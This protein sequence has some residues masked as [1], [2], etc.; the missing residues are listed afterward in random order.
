LLGRVHF[1]KD[2]IGD[3][4][5]ES[6]DEYVVFRKLVLDPTPEQPGQPGALFKVRFRFAKL[7]AAANKRLSLIPAPFIAAQP[8]FRSKTWMLGRKTGMFQGVYEWDS[9]AQAE[10][11]TDSLPL[12]LMKKRAAPGSISFEVVA[13]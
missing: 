3:V 4:H 9:L 8:G 2:C 12:H 11:Y 1:P 5:R 6:D 10:A 7:S 13:Q